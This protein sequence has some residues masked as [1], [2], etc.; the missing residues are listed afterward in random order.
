MRRFVRTPKSKSKNQNQKQSQ[1]KKQSDD[2]FEISLLVI[3]KR[4]G[5]SFE[6]INMMTLQ[7]LFDFVDLWAGG[8]SDGPVEATQADIDKFF[9]M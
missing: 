1:S 9:S 5:L 6:E 4:V 3:A 2:N 7:E 8:N